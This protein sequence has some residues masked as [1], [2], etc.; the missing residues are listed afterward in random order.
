MKTVS[1]C[2]VMLSLCAGAALAGYEGNSGYSY[3]YS[4][5]V[6]GMHPGPSTTEGT[7]SYNELHNPSILNDG[8]ITRA[9]D[10]TPGTAPWAYAMNGSLN[11]G[12][13]FGPWGSGPEGAGYVRFD[14]GSA[15]ALGQVTVHE[16]ILTAH[17][18]G[19]IGGLDV[20]IDGGAPIS[21][22]GFD[23]TGGD[24]IVRAL[25]FD[26]TGYTGQVVKI[27]FANVTGEW[28][29]INEVIFSVPEPATLAMLGIG[30]L[31]TAL[32]K[33]KK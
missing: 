31:F 14:F 2:L 8:Q 4:W 22:T 18:I 15:K 16:A 33:G 24:G 6:A 21:F 20:I 1:L 3:T 26:L 28:E 19:A 7:A 25:T 23:T 32:R 9:T 17:G 27:A 30:G 10:F 5:S 29:S 11:N 13:F 12:V